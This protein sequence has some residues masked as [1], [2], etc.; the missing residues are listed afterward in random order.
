VLGVIIIIYFKGQPTRYKTASEL[1]TLLPSRL[2]ILLPI[3]TMMTHRIPYTWTY[4]IPQCLQFYKYFP[5]DES[6]R[7][8]TGSRFFLKIKKIK[9]V[10]CVQLVGIIL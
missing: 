10:A 5:E 3:L 6:L 1:R 4:I 7:L 9:I 2:L 8:K